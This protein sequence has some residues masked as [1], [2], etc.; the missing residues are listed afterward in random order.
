MASKGLSGGHRELIEDG[1]T[2]I[3]FQADNPHALATKVLDLINTPERWPALRA[4]AREFVE[5]ERNWPRSVA[6]YEKVYGTL[7]SVK[8]S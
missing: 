1:E 4:A 8:S 5:K 7:G 3:L 6:R 2:G